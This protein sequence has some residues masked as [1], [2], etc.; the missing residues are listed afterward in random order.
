MIYRASTRASSPKG[1]INPESARC[2]VSNCNAVT[3]SVLPAPVS[4][5]KAVIPDE[6]ISEAF[7]M[8]PRLLTCISSN[9][10]SLEEVVLATSDICDS[11]PL[12]TDLTDQISP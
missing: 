1:P 9:R 8:T 7:S 10:V 4:P 11:V 12:P 5:V 2:P 6:K 3:I